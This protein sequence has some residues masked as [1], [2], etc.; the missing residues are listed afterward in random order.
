MRCQRRISV[1][2][3]ININDI[4]A[5]GDFSISSIDTETKGDIN[6]MNYELLTGDWKH[7]CFFDKEFLGKDE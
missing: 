2:E 4:I 1:L 6:K 3:N 7:I 5:N